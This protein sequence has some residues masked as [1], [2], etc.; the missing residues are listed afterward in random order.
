MCLVRPSSAPASQFLCICRMCVKCDTHIEQAEVTDHHSSK[1][2]IFLRNTFRRLISIGTYFTLKCALPP[3][4]RSCIKRDQKSFKFSPKYG[5]VDSITWF[6]LLN[7]TRFSIK[8]TYYPQRK[9]RKISSPYNTNN[10]ISGSTSYIPLLRKESSV[11]QATK[12][13][14]SQVKVSLTLLKIKELQQRNHSDLMPV[15]TKLDA[16]SRIWSKNILYCST[17]SWQF[18]G[19]ST[20]KYKLVIPQSIIACSTRVFKPLSQ[21]ML[22]YSL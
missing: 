1:S 13:S 18:I 16:R 7:R 5:I 8:S 21:I 10:P 2:A 14:I 6:M 20:W 19:K 22:V 4:Y 11:I 9:I 12:W 3:Y 17:I 15:G